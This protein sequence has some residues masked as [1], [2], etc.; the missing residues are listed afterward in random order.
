MNFFFWSDLNRVVIYEIVKEKIVFDCYKVLN[1]FSISMHSM[2][3]GKSKQLKDVLKNEL[4]S[5][6]LRLVVDVFASPSSGTQTQ[7]E[8]FESLYEKDNEGDHLLV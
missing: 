4:K 6:E 8:V 5:I 7:V 1:H 2:F 3:C